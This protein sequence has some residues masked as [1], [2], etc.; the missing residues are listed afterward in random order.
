MPGRQG[1]FFSSNVRKV[2]MTLGRVF[3]TTLFLQPSEVEPIRSVV[4]ESPQAV[5]VAWLVLPGQTIAPH[6][7]PDGKDTWNIVSGSGKYQVNASGDTVSIKAG[8][9]V[10]APRS[11]V[12]G[13]HNAGHEPL[14]F[15]SVV[16]PGTT[17]YLPL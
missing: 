15:V 12:H 14:I 7:H 11:A 2:H 5:V 4:S 9:N 6:T 16:C 17:G 13:V 10:V 3:Q 8:D 1:R